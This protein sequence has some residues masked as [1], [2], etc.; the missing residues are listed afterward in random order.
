MKPRLPNK[1]VN[2]LIVM[3]YAGASE[4]AKHFSALRTLNALL[5]GST[6]HLITRQVT[7]GKLLESQMSEVVAEVANANYKAHWASSDPRAK[8]LI[9]DPAQDVLRCH[10]S[11][12]D[13]FV[14]FDPFYQQFMLPNNWRWTLAGSFESGA[15]DVGIITCVRAASSP[16]FEDWAAELLHQLLPHFEGASA[17]AHKLKHQAVATQSTLE[18][19]HLLP[20][21]CLFTDKVGRCMEGNDAF[22]R[23][24][25][26]LSMKLAT[27]RVRFNQ[28]S[29]Q[30]Q[31]QNAL[32]ETHATAVARSFEFTALNGKHC[33]VHLLPWQSVDQDTAGAEGNLILAIFD[34]QVAA[35]EVQE[36][37]T[38][39]ALAA[40][41]TRAEAEVL[42]GLLKGLPAKA[43]ATYRSA[44]VNTVRSQIVAILEKTGHKSQKELMASFGSSVLPDSV[45]ANSFLPSSN[46]VP[47]QR[48]SRLPFKSPSV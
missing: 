1:E 24:M 38:S 41:L 16:P 14:A 12:D 46:P 4:P 25:A 29:V 28:V 15:G 35:A 13:A 40:R 43:I 18:M 33:K 3:I 32:F 9:A 42:T 22:S 23:A 21:P 20:T 10:E 26:P 45:F 36:E 27:G 34:L 39:R 44:S 6:V 31:W 17:M 2:S 7:S 19:F 48:A 30:A 47:M 11:F 8:A 5:A 37:P